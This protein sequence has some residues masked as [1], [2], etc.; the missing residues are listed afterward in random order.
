MKKDTRVYPEVF[1][2]ALETSNEA[3]AYAKSE[4][5][6]R[7]EDLLT[8]G[9]GQMVPAALEIEMNATSRTL[10]Q[11]RRLGTPASGEKL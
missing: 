5:T 3:E 6:L 7:S 1:P 2:F 11:D 10:G 4:M 8:T 9:V